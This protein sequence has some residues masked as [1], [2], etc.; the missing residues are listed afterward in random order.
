MA[1]AA[2]LAGCGGRPD[3]AQKACGDDRSALAKLPPVHRLADAATGLRAA[4]AAERDALAA[5]GG[6]DPLAPRLRGA[7]VTAEQALAGVEADPLRTPTMS[8]LR[9]GVPAA[10]RAVATARQ[11]LAELCR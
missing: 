6:D 7:I 4:L 10:R 3:R 9:T 8:P 1:A 11:L 5:V 2:L